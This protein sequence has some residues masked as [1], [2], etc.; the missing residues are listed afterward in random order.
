[1]GPTPARNALAGFF[2]HVE[3]EMMTQAGLTPMQAIVAPPAKGPS[4]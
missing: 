3:L 2:E 1:M 4:S